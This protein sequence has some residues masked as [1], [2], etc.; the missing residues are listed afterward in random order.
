M[1][2]ARA[3]LYVRQ[4]VEPPPRNTLFSCRLASYPRVAPAGETGAR[5]RA[6][7]EGMSASICREIATLAIWTG[8]GKRT[9]DVRPGPPTRRPTPKGAVD[10]FASL[11]CTADRASPS[12]TH[13]VSSNVVRSGDASRGPMARI[14]FPPP[15]TNTNSITATYG[16]R[17]RA[18]RETGERRRKADEDQ[19]QRNP[20]LCLPALHPARPQ[21]A[22]RRVTS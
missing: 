7:G 10:V 8:C 18:A 5:N 20:L 21:A 6:I 15:A 16:C 14:H 9:D 3:R 13:E 1:S 4:A 12:A 19:A 11:R 17:R 22:C 2:R